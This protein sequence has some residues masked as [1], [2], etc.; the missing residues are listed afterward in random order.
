MRVFGGFWSFESGLERM[1]CTL[2]EMSSNEWNAFHDLTQFF[3]CLSKLLVLQTK[4][5]RMVSSGLE[6]SPNASSTQLL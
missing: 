2:S 1:E 5:P 3:S 6:A 4:N